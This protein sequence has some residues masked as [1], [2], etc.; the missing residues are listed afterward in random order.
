MQLSELTPTELAYFDPGD[1]R[2]LAYRHREPKAGS[3]TVLF[4]PGYASA[5]SGRPR[6]APVRQAPMRQ[7]G[8]SCDSLH[9]AVELDQD[10]VDLVRL[11]QA[12]AAV[13]DQS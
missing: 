5:L 13:L 8:R 6:E 11:A 2:R 10:R 4:L 3:P 1:G 7:T 9:Q 12:V